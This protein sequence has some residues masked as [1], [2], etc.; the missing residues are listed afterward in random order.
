MTATAF[1][2]S[3]GWGEVTRGL[4]RT[5]HRLLAMLRPD[6]DARRRADLSLTAVLKIVESGQRVAVKFLSPAALTGSFSAE[7][8]LMRSRRAP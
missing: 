8:Y 4:Q 1:A 5:S 3:S 2:S 7:T 6:L